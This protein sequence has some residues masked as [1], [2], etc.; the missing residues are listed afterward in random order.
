[1]DYIRAV[2]W[3]VRYPDGQE[4]FE[5]RV[6]R[7]GTKAECEGASLGDAMNRAT[8]AL[9]DTEGEP[10]GPADVLVP[11]SEWDKTAESGH[12]SELIK[13]GEEIRAQ[14][15][16]VRA[17]RPAYLDR[18]TLERLEDLPEETTGEPE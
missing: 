2:V 1:M 4:K 11:L 9:G 6:M 7:I 8:E 17:A 16:S 13:T 15:R 18:A 12:L 5:S 14:R 3:G 10:F